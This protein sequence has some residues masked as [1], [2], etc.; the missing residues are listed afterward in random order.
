VSPKGFVVGKTTGIPDTNA[1]RSLPAKQMSAAASVT[2][3]APEASTGFRMTNNSMA[4]ASI[5]ELKETASVYSKM[6]EPYHR[7]NL[8]NTRG[9]GGM[10]KGPS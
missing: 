8:T 3:Y 6:H 9:L 4:H 2:A 7:V 5:G 1:L 10:K